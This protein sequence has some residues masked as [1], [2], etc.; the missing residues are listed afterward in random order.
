MKLFTALAAIALASIPLNA[1]GVFNDRS[2]SS[3]KPAVAL[4]EAQLKAHAENN[5]VGKALIACETLVRNSLKNPPSYKR[6][7]N[8][9]ELKESEQ[10][11]YSA[12]NSFGA[13]VRSSFDCSPFVTAALGKVT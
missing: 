6:V 5:A 8:R 3:S 2:T 1:C 9:W 13:V 4:T 11:I 12:T 7:S 10:L